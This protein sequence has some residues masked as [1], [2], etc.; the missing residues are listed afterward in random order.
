MSDPIWDLSDEALARRLAELPRHR[1]PG[2]L[3]A[4]I[5]EETAPRPLHGLPW[6]SPVLAAAATALA[7]V[8]VFMPMLR[9]GSLM[10][11]TRRLVDAVVAEHTRVLLWGARREIMPAGFASLAPEVGIGLARAFVGDDEFTLLGAQPVYLDRRR[12]IALHYRDIR[13]ELVTYV[14][15]PAPG[16]S[17][18]DGKRVRIDR[19]KPALVREQ[20]LG[21]WVWM[22]GQLA[23]VLVAK[24]DSDADLD[25]F[26]DY[27]LRVRT[28]SEPYVAY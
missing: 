12:G 11:P 18:P 5:I 3:R 21:A 26:K 20:D 22:Q 28:S 1:A 7:L 8:L 27:F 2:S 13:G 6:F 25:R 9:P 15:V 14:I 19:F 17:I 24:L 4:R 16:L 23:C 10:D